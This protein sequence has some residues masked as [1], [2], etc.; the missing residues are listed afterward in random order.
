MSE[1]DRYEILSVESVAG[2]IVTLKSLAKNDFSGSAI[3]VPLRIA[4]PSDESTSTSLLRGFDKHSM[5]YDLDETQIL[6]P[7]PV[8][9]FER[10][11]DRLVF[12]FRPDRTKDVTTQYNRLRETLGMV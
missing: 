2:Q 6:K 11:N 9:D 1:Y 10:L 3:V 4:S 8:D 7:A 12:P 5:T